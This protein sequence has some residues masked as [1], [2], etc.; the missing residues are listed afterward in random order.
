MAAVIDDEQLRAQAASSTLAPDDARARRE[1][2]GQELQAQQR[3]FTRFT[4]RLEQSE[5]LGERLDAHIRSCAAQ[6]ARAEELTRLAQDIRGTSVSDRTMGL[7]SYVLAAELSDII[8]AA[9]VR[10][11]EMSSGRYE[12]QHDGEQ[13]GAARFGLGIQ[14]LDAHTGRARSAASLSGGETF[15]ASLALAL[16]LADVVSS[17]AGGVSLDT[18]FID[19]GFGSLDQETL[20]TAMNVLDE[21]RRGGRTVGVISHVTTMHEAIP[22]QLEVVAT[23]SGESIIRPPRFGTEL[24]RPAA[25]GDSES[26]S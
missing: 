21:L 5:Q 2:L 13:H 11:H 23:P 8:E 3:L 12:L 7:E 1:A 18:L 15:L 14:V 24:L 22:A 10:L 25:G 16:G 9:N 6:A 20:A 4:D 26:G 17:R 19:E